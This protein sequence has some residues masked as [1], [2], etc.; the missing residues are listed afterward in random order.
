MRPA[1]SPRNLTDVDKKEMAATTV[2]VRNMA[3]GVAQGLIYR[4]IAN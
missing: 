4:K 1:P 2:V 3:L